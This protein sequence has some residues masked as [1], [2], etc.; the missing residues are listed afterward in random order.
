[1]LLGADQQ[2]PRNERPISSPSLDPDPVYI[3]YSFQDLLET[4]NEPCEYEQVEESV[5]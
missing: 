2:S 4:Q 1:M 5:R 3:C